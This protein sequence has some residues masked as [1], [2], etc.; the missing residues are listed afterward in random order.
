MERRWGVVAHQE[1]DDEEDWVDE[2]DE[3]PV[4]RVA[5]ILPGVTVEITSPYDKRYNCAAWAIGDKGHFWDQLNWWPPI[6][7]FGERIDDLAATYA[8]FKFSPCGLDDTLDPGYDKIAIFGEGGEWKHVC[9]QCEDGRWW[10]KLGRSEDVKHALRD[11]EAQPDYGV[12]S[13]I[14]RRRRAA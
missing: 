11:V 10:S 13:L 2:E 14:L 3:D 4:K 5:E 6:A 1:L 9:K 8:H 12:L 7:E